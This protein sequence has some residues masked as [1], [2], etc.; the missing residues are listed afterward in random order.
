MLATIKYF[1]AA[2]ARTQG[3]RV[4]A[5]LSRRTRR[6]VEAADVGAAI[7]HLDTSS[8]FGFRRVAA[9]DLSSIC[10]DG[11]FDRI[12]LSRADFGVS[13]D[14]EL[15]RRFT[16]APESGGLIGREFTGASCMLFLTFFLSASFLFASIHRSCRSL[17][18]LVDAR[19]RS[20]LCA[21]FFMSLIHSLAAI[22]CS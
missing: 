12:H 1:Q 8:N 5:C 22:R 19:N 10:L 20:V 3:E 9:T 13:F 4:D 15:E 18:N 14:I 16:H 7:C 2:G 17:A 6:F 11:D 21:C